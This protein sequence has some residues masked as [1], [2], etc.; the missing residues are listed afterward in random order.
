MSITLY[1]DN[2]FEYLTRNLLDFSVMRS[3]VAFDGFSAKARNETIINIISSADKIVEQLNLIIEDIKLNYHPDCQVVVFDVTELTEISEIFSD[4]L[5]MTNEYAKKKLDENIQKTRHIDNRIERC[6]HNIEELKNAIADRFL[7][8]EDKYELLFEIEEKYKKDFPDN[9]CKLYKEIEDEQP[10]KTEIEKRKYEEKNRNYEEYVFST[11]KEK[12]K[13]RINEKLLY[14]QSEL[15]KENVKLKQQLRQRNEIKKKNKTSYIENCIEYLNIS[16]NSILYAKYAVNTLFCIDFDD[17]EFDWSTLSKERR[18]CLFAIYNHPWDIGIKIPECTF[19]Y[20]MKEKNQLTF[21]ENYSCEK[22]KSNKNKPFI[23][24][25]NDFKDKELIELQEYKCT[26]ISEIIN[27]LFYQL[28]ISN[29][30]VNKCSNCNRY[31]LPKSK[32][33]EKYCDGISPQNPQK[34]CKDFG[35]KKTYR[36]AI[37]SFPIK[38]K[39]TI[40]SQKYRMRINRAKDDIQKQQYQSEFEAYKSEFE[41]KKKQY[42][43]HQLQEEEFLEWLN[44]Y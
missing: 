30:Q 4:L 43:K 32:T 44:Q 38:D 6:K 20:V 28:K 33:N 11:Y 39:H 15:E 13:D 17:A 18:L 2:N 23:N 37:K 5:K 26:T 9:I 31:F 22:Y 16:K 29:C 34:T 8:P 42:F 1:F 3:A 40:I 10:Y 12:F 14:Y 21:I 27:V 19:T 36:E 7:I 41:I 24:I 25:I 35:P